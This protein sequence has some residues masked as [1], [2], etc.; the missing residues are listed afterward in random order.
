MLSQRD[1][2]FRE[3]RRFFLADQSVAVEL[4]GELSRLPRPLDR[5][6]PHDVSGCRRPNLHPAA[7]AGCEFAPASRSPIYAYYDT[8]LG[9][10]IVGGSMVTFEGLAGRQPSWRIRILAGEDPQPPPDRNRTSRCRCSTGAQ[11]RRWNIS[12]KRCRPAVSCASV[13][14]R[15]GRST[16]NDPRRPADCAQAAT[17]AAL[18]CSAAGALRKPPREDEKRMALAAEPRTWASGCGILLATSFGRA[19]WQ[20]AVRLCPDGP[21]GPRRHPA[22]VH[23]EDARLRDEPL[24]A[25]GGDGHYEFAASDA[26]PDGRC[27]GCRPTGTSSSTAAASRSSRA[28]CSGHHQKQRGGTGACGP[29]QRGGAPLARHNARRNLRLARA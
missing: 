21:A 13:R 11:L 15:Y 25:R 27:G 16:R 8:Y 26:L 10:G 12:G 1:S 17:I 14:S 29:A 24:R 4:R 9:H 20:R 7:G 28:G 23:P 6:L 3:A 2:D 5:S 18:L 22:R 19:T